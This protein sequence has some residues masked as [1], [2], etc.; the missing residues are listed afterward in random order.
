MAA[1]ALA[2]ASLAFEPL[3]AQ[4]A[5]DGRMIY[6]AWDRE[7]IYNIYRLNPETNTAE[8]LTDVV[9]GCF[10]PAIHETREGKPFLIFTGIYMGRIQLFYQDNP[11]VIETLVPNA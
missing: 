10:S 9:T 8:Q 5:P 6:Y 4:Y 2:L 1:P 11:E 3:T 7:D